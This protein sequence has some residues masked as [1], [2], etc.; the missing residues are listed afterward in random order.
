MKIRNAL[1]AQH[2][3]HSPGSIDI[4][5]PRC[6]IATTLICIGCSHRP[7]PLRRLQVLVDCEW[8][9]PL[10]RP[11]STMRTQLAW[12]LRHID[13]GVSPGE[14][15]PKSRIPAGE[16]AQIALGH[17]RSTREDRGLVGCIAPFSPAVYALDLTNVDLR[18]RHPNCSKL[19]RRPMGQGSIAAVRGTVTCVLRRTSNKHF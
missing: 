13:S 5:L 7:L 6:C 17:H 15:I 16:L 1:G 12:S 2:C 18:Q 3:W 9:T 10:P 8:R 4:P 19:P 11:T 14:K